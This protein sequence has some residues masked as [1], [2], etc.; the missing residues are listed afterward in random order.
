MNA[1]LIIDAQF[2]FCHPKGALYVQGAEMDM[3]RLA[4]FIKKNQHKIHHITLTIDS[5]P[6]NHIAH[7]SFWEDENGNFPP[8]F[9]QITLKDVT[10]KRWKPRFETQKA[11]KYLADLEK[12]G[13]FPH[14]IWPEHCLK[15]SLG[16]SID[17]NLMLAVHEWTR[18]GY[19]NNYNDYQTVR[20]GEYALS[21][22]FGIFQA[23][24]PDENVPETQLNTKLLEQLASFDRVFLAGEAKSH[25]V[26]TSLNQLLDYAEANM[27]TLIHKLVILEDCMS[28]VT[29]LAHLGAPAYVRA[30]ALG[31]IFAN[32][33]D[34]L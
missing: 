31:V 3:M 19:D 15:G 22:N 10:E 28:D 17:E 24:I 11:I 18:L 30:K 29:G 34:E 1:L 26:A 33:T 27:P 16:A 13:L 6:V 12:Q 4:S 25:C 20:K 2:D 5:H 14:F 23:Q 9:T 8:P 7:P 32:S 21:E